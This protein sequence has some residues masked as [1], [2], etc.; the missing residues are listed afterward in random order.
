M[1]FQEVIEVN[2]EEGVVEPAQEAEEIL[3]VVQEELM[4]Y[5]DLV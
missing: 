1:D 5:Q 4:T 2:P 3:M